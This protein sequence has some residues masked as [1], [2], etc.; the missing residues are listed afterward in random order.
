[1]FKMPNIKPQQDCQGT[2]PNRTSIENTSTNK[3]VDATEIE[4]TRS[5]LI[6]REITDRD[7]VSG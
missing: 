5:G 2:K 3:F 4:G 7:R 6:L 1:M